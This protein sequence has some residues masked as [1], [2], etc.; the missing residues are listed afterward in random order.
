MYYAERYF[1]NVDD[2]LYRIFSHA[3]FILWMKSCCTKSAGNKMLPYYMLAFG[4][5]LSDRRDG[6]IGLRRY[7][8]I[9]RF[10]IQRSHHALSLQLAQS[11]LIMGL[12][13]YA[14]DSGVGSWESIGAA[15]RVLPGLRYN[16]GSAVAIV[17]Q[18]KACDMGCIHRR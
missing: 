12:W 10:A 6:V 13:S 18:D 1:F 8:R 15:G 11:H 4:S 16:M 3:R 17:D 14:T 7:S 5:L 9:A 2:S